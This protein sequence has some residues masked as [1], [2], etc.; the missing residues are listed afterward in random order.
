ME[1]HKRNGFIFLYYCIILIST[2]KSFKIKI[3]VNFLYAFGP[4]LGDS[5]QGLGFRQGLGLGLRTL[6]VKE[7]HYFCLPYIQMFISAPTDFGYIVYPNA[8]GIPTFIDSSILIW[9]HSEEIS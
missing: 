5:M 1:K 3:E 2:A 6:I 9:L 8:R 7:N 4:G